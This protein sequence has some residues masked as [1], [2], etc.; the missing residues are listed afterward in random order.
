MR[1]DQPRAVVAVVAADQHP[2]AALQRLAGGLGQPDHPGQL[3]AVERAVRDRPDLVV[4]ARVGAVTG[5]PQQRL[6]EIELVPHDGG[7]QTPRTARELVPAHPQTGHD[8][9]PGHVRGRYIGSSPVGTH[10]RLPG[11]RAAARPHRSPR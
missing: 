7:L 8:L 1:D 4:D 9:V 10:R 2:A 6:D 5:Q 3:G 11:R